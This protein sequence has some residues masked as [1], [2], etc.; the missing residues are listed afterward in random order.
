MKRLIL[1]AAI[2]GVLLALLVAWA[3]QDRL[4]ETVNDL[5]R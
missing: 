2:T 3:L 5:L 4:I 1:L